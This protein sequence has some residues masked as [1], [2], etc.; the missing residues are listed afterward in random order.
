MKRMTL[1]L[2]V[3]PMLFLLWLGMPADVTGGVPFQTRIVDQEGRA[4]PHVRLTTDNGIVCYT[5]R[6]GEVAWSES[7]LMNRDVHFTIE[8]PGYHFTG[9]GTTLRV[10]R[11]GH[12]ELKILQGRVRLNV[13]GWL[14]KLSWTG[15]QFLFSF[16]RK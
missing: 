12:A 8:S 6:N 5:Q 9:G 10:T 7:S 1:R 15:R 13:A 16:L 14:S 2:F 4:V 11:G 3:L